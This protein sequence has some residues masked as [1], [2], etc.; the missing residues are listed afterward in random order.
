MDRDSPILLEN[1]PQS[2]FI[3]L[4]FL[5]WFSLVNNPLISCL[6][7]RMCINQNIVSW[8]CAGEEA[9]EKSWKGLTLFLCRLALYSLFPLL[10]D[11]R[12]AVK[13]VWYKPPGFYS[14]GGGGVCLPS[15]LF[16][17]DRLSTTPHFQLQL[18]N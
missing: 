12:A 1:S 10:C 17:G 3:D 13:P 18:T 2:V 7:W 6:G 16:S 11:T 4:Y 14:I 5:S 9:G 8:P 15:F